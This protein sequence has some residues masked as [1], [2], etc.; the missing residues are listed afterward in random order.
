MALLHIDKVPSNRAAFAA[1]VI[2]ISKRLDIDPNWLM[3]VIYIETAHSMKASARNP[4]SRATGLI[5]FMPNTAVELGTTVEELQTMSNLDQLDYVY[6][7]LR[8][9][10]KKLKSFRDLYFSVFFPRAMDKPG[11]WTLKTD[12]ITAAKIAKQNP[13]YD[14]DLDQKIT[15]KEVEKVILK[16]DPRKYREGFKKKT[17]HNA[18]SCRFV[19][20][21]CGHVHEYILAK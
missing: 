5:Q 8:P 10:K 14:I 1:K 3:Q 9:Y 15:V 17:S 13:A 12:T 18:N 20:V 11:S 21:N 19:C 16:H 6:M 7:Y 4:Y 2:D